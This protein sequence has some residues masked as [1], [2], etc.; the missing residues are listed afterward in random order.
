MTSTDKIKK[1]CEQESILLLN[2]NFE[3][4]KIKFYLMSLYLNDIVKPV[5]NRLTVSEQNMLAH[6]IDFSIQKG[7][8]VQD[9]EKYDELISFL[10]K[11]KAIR[12]KPIFNTNKTNLVN[13]GYLEKGVGRNSV[14]VPKIMLQ[15]MKH[16]NINIFLSKH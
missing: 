4:D 13:K 1:F 14:V 5:N 10:I 8:V 6:I 15:A 12:N 9:K 2:L 16:G 3:G 11:K 7:N